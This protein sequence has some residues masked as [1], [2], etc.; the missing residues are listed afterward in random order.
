MNLLGRV[1]LGFLGFC[2]IGCASNHYTVQVLHD[3]T[4][5][6]LA[7][8]TLYGSSWEAKQGSIWPSAKR[9]DWGEQ[10]TDEHGQCIFPSPGSGKSQLT[11]VTPV[12]L[13]AYDF[14][15]QSTDI[16]DSKTRNIVIHLRPREAN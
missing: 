8:V 3:E 10:V 9:V 14:P 2:L 4:H 11:S 1:M 6:P 12:L 5:Q 15:I 16:Y 13:H 7:G